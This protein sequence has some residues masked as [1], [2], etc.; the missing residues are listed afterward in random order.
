MVKENIEPY[1]L[2]TKKKLDYYKSLLDK[3][4]ESYGLQNLPANQDKS[5]EKQKGKETEIENDNV[6]TTSQSEK[7]QEE[8]EEKEKE[9]GNIDDIDDIDKESAPISNNEMND[10]NIID[11]EK[12]NLLHDEAEEVEELEEQ[13]LKPKKRKPK[14]VKSNITSMFNP[15]PDINIKKNYKKLFKT[16]CHHVSTTPKLDRKLSK[17]P[18]LENILQNAFSKKK[19]FVADEEKFYKTL[20]PYKFL[21]LIPNEYKINFFCN[22]TIKS[23]YKLSQ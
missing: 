13:N 3:F 18:H 7:D 11:A 17:I 10:C 23:W 20:E 21:Y 15:L 1:V 4:S 8:E 6:W 22:N 14:C 5:E 12:D 19:T 9:L 16:F 2:I